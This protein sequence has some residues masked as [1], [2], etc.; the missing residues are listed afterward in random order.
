MIKVRVVRISIGTVAETED[1]S[2][3][4]KTDF[5]LNGIKV[6]KFK[7]HEHCNRCIDIIVC[8]NSSLV[9]K[10]RNEIE[11]RDLKGVGG[12]IT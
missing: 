9:T 5:E 8:T 7:S 10:M 6:R 4:G 3:S 11:V 2:G 12:S 1:N